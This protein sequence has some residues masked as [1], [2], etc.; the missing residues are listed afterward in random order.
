MWA[1]LKAMPT[2]GKVILGVVFL[3]FVYVSGHHGRRPTPSPFIGPGPNGEDDGPRAERASLDENSKSQL[4]AKYEAESA[5]IMASV[6]KCHDDSVA[7]A[8]N[9]AMNGMMPGEAPCTQNYPQWMARG[10]LL[11]TYIQRLKTGNMNLTVCEA[12]ANVRGCGALEASAPPSS[13]RDGET[14]SNGDRE[15][16]ATDRWDRGAIRGTSIY[17]DRYGEKHELATAPYYFEDV[18]HG[19]YIP[20]NSSTPPD[21]AGDYVL[22]TQQD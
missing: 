20:S 22:M 10:A 18:V 3:F 17:V 15:L 8:Q 11:A 1:K 4:I 5:Q 6:Q 14:S 13:L 19:T 21:N 7:A 2:Y 12:N 9:A 16:E